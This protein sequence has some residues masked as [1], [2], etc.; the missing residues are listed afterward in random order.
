MERTIIRI[1]KYLQ[2]AM[3]LVDKKIGEAIAEQ[4]LFNKIEKEL[5]G[6]SIFEYEVVHFNVVKEINEQVI[7]IHRGDKGDN[8]QQTYQIYRGYAIVEYN[9]IPKEEEK[10]EEEEKWFIRYVDIRSVDHNYSTYVTLVSSL[11]RTRD[12]KIHN[13]LTEE[14]IESL[15][16]QEEVYINETTGV[17]IF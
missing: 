7:E 16:N 17:I 4:E 14:A 1:D 11:G 12:K 9:S 10:E 2:V 13:D 8:I 15:T 3:E 6:K 5:F